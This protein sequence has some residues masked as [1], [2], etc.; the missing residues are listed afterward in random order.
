MAVDAGGNVFIAGSDLPGG[1]F[2]LWSVNGGSRE[3]LASLPG[4]CIRI[5]ILASPADDTR[6][7]GSRAA[8]GGSNRAKAAVSH[9]CDWNTLLYANGLHQVSAI[10]TDEAGAQSS[11]VITVNVA[12]V[13][14][15]LTGQRFSDHSWLITKNYIKVRLAVE[16]GAGAPVVKYVVYRRVAGGGE[17]VARE[18]LPNEVRDG[19]CEFTDSAPDGGQP[20]TYR[21]VA[22]A[23]GDVIIGA[24]SRNNP[25]T[26]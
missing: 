7:D 5:A 8:A 24:A 18:F 3:R 26:R 9:A 21:A 20:V 25:I 19:A 10:A 15:S 14:L 1:T 12:N 22:L 13:G 17:Q 11:D 6:S 2:G 16:N 4:A 23:A